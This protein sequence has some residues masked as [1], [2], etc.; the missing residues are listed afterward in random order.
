MPQQTESRAERDALVVEPMSTPEH[1]RAFKE[2]NEEWVRTLFSIEAADSKI[3]DHPE[4]IVADGGQ[5][6]IARAGAEI[7]GC[8]ALI[9]M[10][11]GVFEVSKMAVPP[12]Y[13]GRGIGRVV[14]EA[15]VAHARAIGA[16]SLYL[17]S[18]RKLANAVHLYESIGFV[19]VQP[20]APS[21]YARADVFMSYDLS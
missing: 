20:H 6:L 1:A 13:R 7:L 8:G 19:H 2:M 11:D 16:T 10:G 4:R 12:Q 3:L 14:L 5:V 21:P 18:N 15:L 9:A 17:E